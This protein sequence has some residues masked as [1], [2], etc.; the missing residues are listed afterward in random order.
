MRKQFKNLLICIIF[1]AVLTVGK[2]Q[3]VFAAS[4]SMNLTAINLPPAAGSQE[5]AD[6]GDAGGEAVLVESQGKYLL[7]DCGK[8]EVSDTLV[9]N[10]KNAGV[11][12]LDVYISHTHNDHRGGLQAVCDNFKV[13]KIYLP[14]TSIGTEYRES[15]SGTTQATIYRIMTQIAEKEGSQVIYLKKGSQFS[16]GNVQAQVLGPVGNYKLSQFKSEAGVSGSQSGHYLNNCSLTTMLT[17]GNTKFLTGGDIEE[18]EENA[19]LNAYGAGLKADIL[20]LSHHGLPT[21]NTEAFIQAVSPD[22]S[23]GE[24]ASYVGTTQ[25]SDGKVV[26]KTYTAQSRAMDYGFCYMVGDEGKNLVICI[27]DN[28]ISMYRSSVSNAN[29]MTGWVKIQ[30]IEQVKSGAY[31]GE[32]M[33]YIDSST[34]KA[35]TGIQNIGGKYYYLGTGGCMEKGYYENGKYVPYRS[36]GKKIR[37]FSSDGEMTVGFKTINGNKFFFDQEGYKFFGDKKWNIYLLN[38]KYYAVN[39]NGA[40]F[41]NKGKG[42]WKKYSSTKFRYFKSS[43]EMETGWKKV[44]GKYYYLNTSNGYRTLGAKKIDKY[45]YFFH[46]QYGYRVDSKWIESKSGDKYLLDKNGRAYTGLK[47]HEKQYYGF[48]ENTAVMLKGLAQ[49]NNKVYYFDPKTGIGARNANVKLSGKTYKTNGK[50]QVKN[51]P[52]FMKKKVSDV[53]L[54]AGS[55]NVKVKFKKMS[56]ISGYEVYISDTKNG[57]YENAAT[58]KK[59]SK[60]STTIKNLKT[61]KIYYIKVRAYKTLGKTKAYTRYSDI[62][63]VVIQ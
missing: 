51:P 54:T 28:R 58:L 53:K 37:H 56:G 20:K 15:G 13:N 11:T 39:E 59:A 16:F 27:A 1:M 22:Y 26:K 14:D 33:F 61:G 17:C 63:T 48:D 55:N 3:N 34:G 6:G 47:K 9:Q 62:K 2:N 21:S 57:L 7:M 38:G 25:T 10:L 50:A 52:A 45:I 35:L 46:E 29:Q 40:I 41:T 44:K 19:L 23:F 36:Y 31:T 60:T 43:G 5:D 8:E 4:S 30:G 42:G 32:N 24:N 49:I 12:E 18:E